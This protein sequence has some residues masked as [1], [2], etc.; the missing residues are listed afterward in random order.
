MIQV[1]FTENNESL[2]VNTITT[3]IIAIMT[4]HF[5][6]INTDHVAWEG[7]KATFWMVIAT[8]TFLL[9]Q[10]ER[11]NPKGIKRELITKHILIGNF[12]NN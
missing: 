3:T 1:T 10:K 7:G 8:M 11:E 5:H 9:C 6:G 12:C 2:C 4:I